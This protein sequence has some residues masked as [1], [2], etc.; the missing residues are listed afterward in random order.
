M[1]TDHFTRYSQAYVT[2]NQQAVTAAKVF[3]NQFVTNYGYPERILTDQAQ[4]F[5]GKL[6]EALCKEAKIK[7]DKDKS[8]SSTN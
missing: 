2:N 7:E 6:Y 8:L 5:N 3:I 4:A 1:I